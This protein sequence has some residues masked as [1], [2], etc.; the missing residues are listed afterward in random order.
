MRKIA[1]IIV[2]LLLVAGFAYGEMLSYTPALVLL[3]GVTA[4]GDGDAVDLGMFTGKVTCVVDVGGTAPTSV[5][6]A[7]KGSIDDDNYTSIASHTYTIAS[8]NDTF[9]IVNQYCK[10]VKGNFTSKVGGAADTSVTL[11]CMAGGN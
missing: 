11:T 7:V 2:S 9:T 8:A 5:T 3:D 6:V 4:T 10:Y 1:V